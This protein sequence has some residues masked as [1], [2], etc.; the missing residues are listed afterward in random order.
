[1]RVWFN[2]WFS[3]AYYFIKY[4][5][6]HYYY[7]IGSNYRDNCVYRT[8]ADVFY[9]EP[10]IYGDEYV[11]W[12]LDFCYKHNVDVFVP[13]KGMSEI[14]H[15]IEEFDALG[16]KVMCERNKEMFDILNSKSKTAEYFKQLNIVS[17]PEYRLATTASEFK[18]A[19]DSLEQSYSD[20]CMK[21][22]CDEGGTSYK[23]IRRKGMSMNRFTEADAY[24]ISIEEAICC[25]ATVDSFK[26]MV[27]MPYL[28]GTE[29]SVDCLGVGDSFIAIPRYKLSNRV[30]RFEQDIFIYETCKKFW[31]NSKLECPFNVQFR[32]DGVGTPYLLEVN[33]R[34]SGGSWKAKNLGFDF[35]SMA[36]SKLIG[37]EVHCKDINFE[38]VSLA[39]IEGV[40]QL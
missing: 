18:S 25:M 9:K 13:R 33:T 17:V 11:D 4:L 15:R 40:L 1:M 21:Y 28:S 27:I 26:P 31:Q 6:S 14:V 37:E 16:V 36:V 10:M 19:C 39:N 24:S 32:Y 5:Q 38:P 29:I 35:I 34:L 23:R 7:V 20:L 2:H 3:T 8:N 12:C 30:T 22:D